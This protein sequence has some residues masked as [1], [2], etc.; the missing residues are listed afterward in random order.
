MNSS[1]LNFQL[2][3]SED[4]ILTANPFAVE[5]FLTLCDISSMSLHGDD[6]AANGMV[7]GVDELGIGDWP[8]RWAHPN[9]IMYSGYARAY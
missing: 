4:L 5:N 1:I 9:S 7:L 3:L 8:G 6:R 2:V